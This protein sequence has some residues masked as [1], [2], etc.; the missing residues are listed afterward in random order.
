MLPAVV[1][2]IGS[3][4]AVMIAPP[5]PLLL[6]TPVGDGEEVLLL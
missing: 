3:S 5:P 2:S 4:L 6:F 1:I